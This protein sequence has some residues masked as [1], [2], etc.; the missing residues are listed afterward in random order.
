LLRA[1]VELEHF[2]QLRLRG[3]EILKQKAHVLYETHP[4][5]L[6]LLYLAFYD[7]K[8]H[9]AFSVSARK[10]KYVIIADKGEMGVRAV[11]E[12]LALKKTPV[13]L[14]SL[15]D[16]K[17]ALQVRLTLE[18]GGF[19]IGLN[20]NFRE[21][22]ANYV[23]ITDRI[24]ETFQEK[25]KKRWREEL[26]QAAIYPGY[27]PLAENAAA[28]QHFRQSGLTFIGPMQDVV[29]RVGDKRKFR[30]LAQTID[31]QSVT[32]GL[33]LESKSPKEISRAIRKGLETAKFTLPGR[34]KA[35]NGGGGRGQA[36][37][38]SEEGIDPAIQKVLGEITSYGW[39]PGVMFEQN[40]PE[41]IHL[42][43]QVLRDRYGNA[44]HF[45]MRDCSEQR[46]SQKIQEKRLPRF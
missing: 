35:A 26:A 14:H 17:N 25:F 29:E 27:G 40:I 6:D 5:V 4:L 24:L 45:G 33:I 36:V 30:L 20:G 43:V 41:T 12:A 1:L 38:Q 28:I 46:A 21:S 44:R 7:L 39:D 3:R 11:R 15:Q 13:I 31:P 22:Y 42:E 32:P 19:A 9:P 16:D 18:N 23:Q 34:I 10:L 2:P 8:T 37:I